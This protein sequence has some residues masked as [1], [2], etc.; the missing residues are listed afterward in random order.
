MIKNINIDGNVDSIKLRINF[1]DKDY[2]DKILDELLDFIISKNWCMFI[3]IK[4]QLMNI[5][6]SEN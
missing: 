6:K 4:N 1:I 3:M 2:R 5:V